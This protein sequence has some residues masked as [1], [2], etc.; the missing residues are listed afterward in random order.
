[1][2]GWHAMGYNIYVIMYIQGVLTF[3]V[4]TSDFT[5]LFY[6]P[7]N[8]HFKK[9]PIFNANLLEKFQVSF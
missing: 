4:Q 1:M 9:Y 2:K 5:F 6:T 3:L 8:I 7:K